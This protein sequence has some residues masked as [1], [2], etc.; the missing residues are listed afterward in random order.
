MSTASEAIKQVSSTENQGLAVQSSKP[1]LLEM[2]ASQYN[3]DWRKFQDVLLKTIF[4]QNQVAT[5][6]QLASFCAVAHEYRLNP[7]VKHIYAFPSK[8]GG[9]VPIVSI[10]GW[11]SLVQRNTLYDGHSFAYT[12]KDGEVGG[13]LVSAT[14]I[15]RRKDLQAPIEHT[16]FMEECARDT[17]PWKK[18][19]R[20]MLTH[21]AFIQASRYAFGLSGIY[22]PDEGERIAEGEM[23]EPKPAAEIKQPKR[24]EDNPHTSGIVSHFTTSNL[25]LSSA[26]ITTVTTPSNVFIEGDQVFS[27]GIIAKDKDPVQDSDDKAAPSSLEPSAEVTEALSGIFD[28]DQKK[29]TEKRETIGVGRAKRIYAILNTRKI[30]TEEELKAEILAPLKINH[31]QDLPIDLNDEVIKWAESKK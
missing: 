18:W 11:I 2:M 9:I 3:M 1:S 28:S 14:C 25:P 22:D 30:H 10:D 31:L 16:E 24:I 8:G 17:E 29:D 5:M 20:R 26:V 7:L 13:K 4:P 12:W 19:P 27:D 15:L 23:A 21:K 6:E